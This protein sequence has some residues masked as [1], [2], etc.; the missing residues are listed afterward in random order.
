VLPCF[1]LIW[2]DRISGGISPSAVDVAMLRGWAPAQTVAKDA[3]PRAARSW[4]APRRALTALWQ[5]L[6]TP[7]HESLLRVA[8]VEDTPCP[9]PP[10]TAPPSTS[11]DRAPCATHMSFEEEYLVS[12]AT[13]HPVLREAKRLS[14]LKRMPYRSQTAHRFVEEGFCAQFNDWAR[15][16]MRVQCQG[17]PA[18]AAPRVKG[19]RVCLPALVHL[20][21][22][23]PCSRH[24]PGSFQSWL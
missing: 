4:L 9:A 6:S 20:S 5:R 3:A 17:E 13:L 2:I 19:L 7:R 21:S 14:A 22:S 23:C 10:S 24:L 11:L 8:S 18:L 15:Y 16:M 12:D 1:V